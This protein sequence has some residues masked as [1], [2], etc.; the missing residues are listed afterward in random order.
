[1]TGQKCHTFPPRPRLIILNYHFWQTPR[2]FFAF[3]RLPVE[4]MV[5]QATGTEWSGYPIFISPRPLLPFLFFRRVGPFLDHDHSRIWTK[6]EL[7]IRDQA[8]TA[9]VYN[10]R[11]DLIRKVSKSYSTHLPDASRDI[12]LSFTLVSAEHFRGLVKR[13][14]YLC[15]WE[16]SKKGHTNLLPCLSNLI[17]Q[18][19]LLLV[20][21]VVNGLSTFEETTP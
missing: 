1:M 15:A 12:K 10:H 21:S 11:R 20:E 2:N 17:F 16:G 9:Q 14:S 4:L 13:S 8:Q 7:T 5:K 3:G 18:R 19:G 6:K